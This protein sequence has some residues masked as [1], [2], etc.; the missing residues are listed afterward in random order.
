[1][2]VFLEF[3][4]MKNYIW[5]I[6]VLG[7]SCSNELEQPGQEWKEEGEQFSGAQATVFDQSV[8]AFGHAA[9]N[10]T[11]DK[12]LI[13]VSGNAFF[14]RNWVSS[15]A[16]TVD[17]DGLGPVFNAR[18]CSSC[19]ELD[20]RGAPP[21]TPEEEPVDLLFR[22]SRPGVVEW[23]SIPDVMYGGQFNHLSV[24]GVPPEG[25]VKVVYHYSQGEYADGAPFELRIPTYQFYDLNYGPFA[26]DMQISP[27]IAPH[28][29]GLGLLEAI[30]AATLE[31]FADPDDSDGDGISGRPNYVYNIEKKK[32]TIGRFGWKANQPTVR[33]QVAGAFKGDI[34]ISTSIFPDQPCAEGQIDCQ[35]AMDG[36]DPELS[37]AI[38]DR[39]DL[40]SATLAVPGRRNWENQEVLVG[41][42]LFNQI[43]CVQCHKPKVTTGKHEKIPEFNNL[44]IRPYTDL[45]LHDM[46]EGLADHRP[47]GLANGSEWRTPPLWG[48]GMIETVNQHTFFLH[49]GRARNLEEAILWHGGEGEQSK[50]NFMNLNQMER[51]N[52][53]K[54]LESL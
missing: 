8:H 15:P 50:K 51:N 9:P 34:G 3:H 6:L 37:D 25:K 22:L 41:K 7:F 54:F 30:D 27:R 14:K 18:S 29:V 36:G 38:L 42:G 2:G 23:E 26:A 21:L 17:L 13:F 31:S 44:E 53:I 49:D 45:L 11:G 48:I 19:H 10:L 16:S 39:V 33:Q 20:G 12:D 5:I 28:M 1:M 24:L 46:G 52:L 43:G 40:Y 35:N 4:K 47:D 32:Q